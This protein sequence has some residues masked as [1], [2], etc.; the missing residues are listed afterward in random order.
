MNKTNLL[1][2]FGGKSSE[3]SV[4]LVSASSVIDNIDLEIFNI[5]KVGIT[6][7][8]QWLYTN[9]NSL[10]IKDGTWEKNNENKN[11]TISLNPTKKDLII[12]DDDK[13]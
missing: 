5:I 7:D 10:E 1:I 9:A 8:G 4:S 2:I 12:L 13:N 11:A 6:K 3:H